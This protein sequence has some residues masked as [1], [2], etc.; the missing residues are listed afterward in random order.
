ML[1][2]SK[3]HSI[4][5][6]KYILDNM[7]NMI[8]E[9]KY[10]V[11]A[12]KCCVYKNEYIKTLN[13]DDDFD[14]ELLA[15]L[16]LK[17]KY[18]IED[19]FNKNIHLDLLEGYFWDL[20]YDNKLNYNKIRQLLPKIEVHKSY[21]DLYKYLML[22]KLK[23]YFWTIT[24]PDF[25]YFCHVYNIVI[26]DKNIVEIEPGIYKVGLLFSDYVYTIIYLGVNDCY[27]KEYAIISHNMREYHLILLCNLMK[28]INAVQVPPHKLTKQIHPYI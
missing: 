14:F 10:Y 27:S 7:K 21:R 22:S 24:S 17:L 9:N 4:Y 6:K 16:L 5:F 2:C 11:I 1:S 28:T 25:L 3:V 18:N 26:S 12:L 15:C 8:I 13:I 20:K 23:I 19:E